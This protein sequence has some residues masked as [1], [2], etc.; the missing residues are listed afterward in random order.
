MIFKIQMV[1]NTVVVS[2]SVNKR[3]YIT[4]YGVEY[5]SIEINNY[6]TLV[7]R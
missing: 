2:V 4:W 1:S 6:R 7:L 3:I 5:P